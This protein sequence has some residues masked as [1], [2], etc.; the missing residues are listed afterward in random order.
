MVYL[1][2]DADSDELDIHMKKINLTP[3]L[4]LIDFLELIF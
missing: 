2:S 1:I 3:T 4:D